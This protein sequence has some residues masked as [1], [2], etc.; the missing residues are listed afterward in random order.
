[1]SVRAITSSTSFTSSRTVRSAFST[2]T[3]VAGRIFWVEAGWTQLAVFSQRRWF[4]AA[5]VGMNTILPPIAA[6]CSTAYGLKP[7]TTL[8]STIEA[9]TFVRSSGWCFAIIAI[10]TRRRLL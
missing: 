9:Y 7:P 6:V 1:M 4:S 3:P 8:L 2:A 10:H 5:S